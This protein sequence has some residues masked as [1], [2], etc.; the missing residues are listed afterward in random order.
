MRYL[1]EAIVHRLPGLRLAEGAAI[2]HHAS[3]AARAL[4]GLHVTVD[5]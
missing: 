3:L 4:K 5:R 2:E 1:L